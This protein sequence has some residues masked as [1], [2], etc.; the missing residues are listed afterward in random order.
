[1]RCSDCDHTMNEWKLIGGEAGENRRVIVYSC[2]FPMCSRY[3]LM[4]MAAS[5]P[6]TGKTDPIPKRCSADPSGTGMHD[7]RQIIGSAELFCG[8]CGMKI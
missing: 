2:G 3:G 4:V 6:A 7:F 5:S 8:K 1:M